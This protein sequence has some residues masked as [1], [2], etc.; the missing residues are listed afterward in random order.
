MTAA[1]RPQT[2]RRKPAMQDLDHKTTG[3]GMG[4]GMGAQTASFILGDRLP[5]LDLEKRGLLLF[6][7]VQRA[8]TLSSSGNEAG[9]PQAQTGLGWP[10][11]GLWY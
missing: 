2:R 8:A 3:G 7:A 10:T 9:L 6:I 11:P 5:G 4:A 1:P